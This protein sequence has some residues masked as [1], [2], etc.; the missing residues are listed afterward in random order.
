[1]ES[2]G[3]IGGVGPPCISHTGCTLQQPS[4]KMKYSL[5]GFSI[6]NVCKDLERSPQNVDLTR[7]RNHCQEFGGR[8]SVAAT[9]LDDIDADRRQR[10]H[11]VEAKVERQTTRVVERQCSRGCWEAVSHNDRGSRTLLDHFLTICLISIISYFNPLCSY[12]S[13][14]Y[15]TLF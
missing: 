6:T 8:D 14:I 4:F 1:M 5:V 9:A 7:L 2:H 3:S 13:A 10:R 15:Q 12:Y 11:V